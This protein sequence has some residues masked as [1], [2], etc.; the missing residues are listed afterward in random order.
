MRMVLLV[1]ALVIVNALRGQVDSVQTI[2]E[3]VISAHRS[4]A[5]LEQVARNVTVITRREIERAPVQS[6]AGLLEYALSVD[7]RQRGPLGVQSDASIRGGSFDQTLILLNGVKLT[8][9]QTGHHSMN[10]PVTLDHI[11]RIEVLNGGGSRIFGPNAFAGAINIITKT[12]APNSIQAG[13]IGGGFGLYSG[14]IGATVNTGQWN[15]TVSY[16]RRGSDGFT[17]NTDFKWQ[18]VYVQTAAQLKHHDLLINAGYNQKAFG[19]STFYSA[20]FPNQFEETSTSFASI[21]DVIQVTPDLTIRPRA[22]WREHKDRFE[23]FR[24]DGDYYT[25]TADGFFIMDGDT[26]PSW[27]SGHNYHKTI[28]WG[29]ELNAAYQWVGGT[30]SLGIDYR[31]EDIRS[32]ALGEPLDTPLPVSGEHPNAQ[33]LRRSGREN[34]SIYAEH[35]LSWKSLFVSAGALYNLN[36]DF[37][38]EIFPGIDIAYQ[39]GD[40][41]RPYASWNRSLR[42]PTYTDL[43]YNLGGAVGSIDLKPESSVNYEAGL[44]FFSAPVTGVLSIFR[45]EGRDL[46]DWIQFNGSDVTQAANITTVNVNGIEIGARFN[47]AEWVGER[48]VFSTVNL[49]YTYLQADTASKGYASNYVLD[50]LRHKF[51]LVALQPI[52]E[53]VTVQWNASYQERIGGYFDPVLGAE[54]GFEPVF[55]LDLRITHHSQWFEVFVEASNLFNETYVDIGNVPQPGRW[56]RAGIFLNIS[57]NGR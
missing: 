50:F 24:E 14:R 7:M 42:F 57:A 38:D 15:H 13:A 39:I 55:L 54:R 34:M 47:L 37:D 53:R 22:Y 3:V 18:N 10:L 25:R 44:R 20:N 48:S 35:N 12:D 56:L 27:Y 51:N 6:V 17:R 52:G 33:Y 30:S 26:A 43:Y 28:S 41:F 40:H 46:I 49:S 36:S 16:G 8:D 2:S 32:N 23:L 19:A 31:N 11:E 29:G 9:P 4:P 21:T 1:F 45:R 5:S